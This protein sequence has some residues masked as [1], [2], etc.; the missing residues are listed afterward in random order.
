MG[1]SLVKAEAQSQTHLETR[2]SVWDITQWVVKDFSS[3][4]RQA[5]RAF[6]TQ[7]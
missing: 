6:L 1:D 7:M 4:R 5:K 3:F 2:E